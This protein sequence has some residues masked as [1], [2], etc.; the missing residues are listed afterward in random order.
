MSR[1]TRSGDVRG[2]RRYFPAG[3]PL[4]SANSVGT[5]PGSTSSTPT[6]LGDNSYSRLSARPE[7]ANLVAPYTA[8][9]GAGSS[10]NTLDTKT[11]HPSP[12]SSISGRKVR[13]HSIAPN[14]FV[15][16]IAV[17]S[18]GS[19]SAN[20][21]YKPRPALFIR[22]STPRG[23]R[24]S[25]RRWASRTLLGFRHVPDD[26][27]RVTPALLDNLLAQLCQSVAPSGEENELRPAAR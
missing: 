22:M 4:T 8:L 16:T 25:T 12:L 7:T 6:P 14:R 17:S 10:P 18:S 21:L 27:Q 13:V 24:S 15:S 1:A 2:K 3:V 5:S 19:A 26:D 9:F 20:G 11:T 23:N